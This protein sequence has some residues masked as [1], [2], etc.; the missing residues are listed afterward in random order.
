MDA[1]RIA[2]G[3]YVG[4]VPQTCGAFD[5][6]VL[7]AEEFQDLPLRCTVIRA[8]LDDAVPSREEVRIALWAAR[9]VQK[10]RKKGARV[11]VT[12]AQGRNRSALIAA[13]VLMMDGLSV[14]QAIQLIRE[15]RTRTPY[16]GKPLTNMAFIK[17]LKDYEKMKNRQELRV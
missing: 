1:D 14:D 17:V 7:A 3:L 2:K 11:L 13:L 15:R 4:S 6:V 16:G 5:A 12:C 8:P 9:Q 10:L